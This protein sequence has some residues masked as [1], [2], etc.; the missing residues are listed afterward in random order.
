M[1]LKY[2]PA[3]PTHL[4]G[5]DRARRTMTLRPLHNRRDGNTEPCR[6]RPAGLP[7]K[8][9][10]NYPLAKINRKR[11]GHPMLASI[12]ASIL[13]HKSPQTGIPSD[14]AKTGTA[15][16]ARPVEDHDLVA[17][18]EVERAARRFIEE[19]GIES[20]THQADAMRQRIALGID[21]SE[22]H[23]RFVD[24]L[25]QPQ[26]GDE[27]A[28]ALHKM[29]GEIDDKADAENRADDEPR[30]QPYRIKHMHPVRESLASHGVN[31]ASLSAA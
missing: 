29:I 3:M 9:R 7:G 8:N 28:V 19:I 1:R 22:R 27:T 21:L 17:A 4:P 30:T 23:A 16:A 15:L 25:R 12:P 26:P 5:R 14:S 10:C 18:D 13:N 20:V 11:S 2:A 31:A 6:D 24:L